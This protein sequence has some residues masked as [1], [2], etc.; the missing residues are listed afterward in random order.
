MSKDNQLF[1]DGK[2]S[3]TEA[4]VPAVQSGDRLLEK[5]LASG[6]IEVLERYIALRKSEEER[7]AR[8]D[9]EKHFAQ[10][11]SSL[12][13]VVK[14]KDNGGTKSKY[15]PIEDIQTAWDP[16]I[17]SHGFSYS[18]REEI[19]PDFKGKRIILDIT[20]YGHTKSNY[21]DS[22]QIDGNSAQN[23][24]QVAGA[25]STYGRRYTFIAG[26][27]GKVEGEDSD[28]QIPEDWDILEMDLREWMGSGKL[29]S[30]ACSF[31]TKLLLDEDR[32]T[33]KL[34]LVWKRAKAKV[35]K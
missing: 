30:N 19:V 2:P 17:R 18:W 25:M 5:V 6:N 34:K 14:H 32:D 21:F 20:G 10:M 3:E 33:E 7:Q 1:D 28:G 11:Q 24:I 4:Q 12:P 8:I 27:G 29:D 9:F 13:A 23:A 16:T 15:A 35:N 22:P 26:F 31:I